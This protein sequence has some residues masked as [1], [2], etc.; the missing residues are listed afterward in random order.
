MR[1]MTEKQFLAAQTSP[2]CVCGT[3]TTSIFNDMPLCAEC[4][5]KNKYCEC[6]YLIIGGIVDRCLGCSMKDEQTKKSLRPIVGN[7]FQRC[8]S[9]DGEWW[10]PAID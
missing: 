9:A 4:C 7:F 8:A 10:L 5:A 1:K 6:G 3:E 2:C